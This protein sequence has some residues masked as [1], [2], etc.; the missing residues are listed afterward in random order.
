MFLA[1]GQSIEPSSTILC[2]PFHVPGHWKLGVST[3][4]L[5]HD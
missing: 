2:L 1:Q 4:N 5:E 3:S